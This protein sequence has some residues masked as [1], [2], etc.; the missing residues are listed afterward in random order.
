MDKEIKKIHAELVELQTS[1]EFQNESVVE[2]EK[3]IALQQAEI[4]KL[5][6][7]VEILSLHL[8]SLRQDVVKDIRDE[9]PPPHY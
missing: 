6:K 2:M 1:F 8:K 9:T 3:T 5:Q 7:Q 4:Q